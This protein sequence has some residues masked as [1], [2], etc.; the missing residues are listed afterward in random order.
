[1]GLLG[2]VTSVA[3]YVTRAN[4]LE[5]L[6]MAH[7]DGFSG[8]E[9]NEDHLHCLAAAL[10]SSLDLMRQFA[11][12]HDM[13]NSLHGTLHLPS[14][15][16]E[17]SSARRSAVE[18]TLKTLDFMEQAAIPRIV[19]HS[20]S[21]LPAFFRLR[22]ERANGPAYLVGCHAVKTYGLLAPVLKK[23]RTWRAEKL[24]RNFLL[25][26]SE[27]ASHASEKRVNGEA[28]QIVFEEHYSDAMDYDEVPYGKGKFANVIRGIDSAHHY[29][30]TGRDSDLSH[31]DG[32]I[33]FHAVDTNGTLDDHRTVGTGRVNIDKILLQILARRLTDFIVIEDGNRASALRSKAALETHLRRRQIVGSSFRKSNS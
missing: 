6:A 7:E 12:D 30:R 18:Y 5:A 15:D 25:S 24:H 1:M 26:L 22:G 13:I 9:L 14:L 11:Q 21:D 32:P 27:I 10:P 23:Y 28:I 8:V 33:H 31:L 3:P 29:I 17:N 2:I 16:S 20:F 19:L 4:A